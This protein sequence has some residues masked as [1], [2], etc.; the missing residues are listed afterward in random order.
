MVGRRVV[1]GGGGLVWQDGWK[2]SYEAG[3]DSAS[4]FLGSCSISIRRDWIPT[5]LV[6]ASSSVVESTITELLANVTAYEDPEGETTMRSIAAVRCGK[7]W[8][9]PVASCHMV[10]TVSSPPEMT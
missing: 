4:A 7:C 5:M 9:F 8:G 3:G 1:G 2:I 6:L 10:I